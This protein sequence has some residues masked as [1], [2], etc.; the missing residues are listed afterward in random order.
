MQYFKKMEQGNKR[1][2]T[3]NSCCNL[4]HVFFNNCLFLQKWCETQF[5]QFGS[6]R[7]TESHLAYLNLRHVPYLKRS[8][9]ACQLKSVGDI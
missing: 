9:I 2:D 1:I 7:P 3:S 8:W 6:M 4:Y 5:L